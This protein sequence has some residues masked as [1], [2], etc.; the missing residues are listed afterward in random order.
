ML[1]PPSRD[2]PICLAD[3]IEATVLFSRAAKGTAA[4]SDLFRL[5]QER[6]DSDVA[7]AYLEDARS[8]IRLRSSILGENYPLSLHGN[9]ISLNRTWREAYS[10]SFLLILSLS[11]H[12]SSLRMTQGRARVPSELFEFLVSKAINNY[13]SANSIRFGSVRRPPV[14][15]GFRGA[16][17]YIA[18][19]AHEH[20]GS[21]YGSGG[22]EKDDGLDVIGWIPFGDQEAGQVVFLIQCAIGNDWKG[23][24]STLMGRK[25]DH[26]VL[27]HVTP[28]RGFALPIHHPRTF[29]W[30][31][32]S[33]E[34][35]ILF[36]RLR[37][38]LL[39]GKTI[40]IEAEI[41]E[42]TLKWSQKAI[43]NLNK[44]LEIE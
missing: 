28:V 44:K 41:R 7:E 35:G 4:N 43:A 9:T 27:W 21:S 14:P 30:T 26:H 11:H 23:K 34:A 25:W 40:P 18:T 33:H 24:L 5:L 39:L 15:S 22:R 32:N 10:Y 36:D 13:G 38:V 1:I 31:K 19:A 37:L 3:W 29:E 42:R 17:E 20:L 2:D 8:V 6:H 16:L 12:Y